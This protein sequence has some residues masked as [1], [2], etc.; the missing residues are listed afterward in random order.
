MNR[1]PFILSQLNINIPFQKNKIK[2]E[3]FVHVQLNEHIIFVRVDTGSDAFY[4]QNPPLPVPPYAY[5]AGCD[6]F[7]THL[8]TCR[9][10]LSEAL[11]LYTV[12]GYKLAGLDE[13]TIILKRTVDGELPNVT[14]T[15]YNKKELEQG[16]GVVGRPFVD[17]ITAGTGNFPNQVNIKYKIH[18][19]DESETIHDIERIIDIKID[20]NNLRINNIPNDK[21][22]LTFILKTLK[23]SLKDICWKYLILNESDSNLINL[24]FTHPIKIIQP[25]TFLSLQDCIQFPPGFTH[26]S[27]H[28]VPKKDA[29]A[30]NAKRMYIR[31][32]NDD[33]MMYT[34]QLY[35]KTSNSEGGKIQVFISKS[36][37]RN[38]K[39]KERKELSKTRLFDF[40]EFHIS[41]EILQELDNLYYFFL[42]YN[43]EHISIIEKTDK[44]NTLLPTRKPKKLHSNLI[45]G[46]LP[47]GGKNEPYIC[48]S[49]LR[50]IPYSYYGKCE[51]ITSDIRPFSDK[52]PCCTIQNPMYKGFK[53]R[54][55][56]IIKK[57]GITTILKGDIRQDGYVYLKGVKRP[58]YDIDRNYIILKDT[59]EKIHR[60]VF[61][62]ETV[63]P[64][65]ISIYSHELLSSLFFLL[66]PFITINST[67]TKTWLREILQYYTVQELKNKFDNIIIND[68]SLLRTERNYIKQEGS[69]YSIIVLLINNTYILDYYGNCV[70]YSK[71]NNKKKTITYMLYDPMSIIVQKYKHRSKKEKKT[72]LNENPVT[73]YNYNTKGLIVSNTIRLPLK[74][75]SKNSLGNR[76][77]ELLILPFE[78]L[79]KQDEWIL[80]EKNKIEDKWFIIERNVKKPYLLT[81]TYIESFFL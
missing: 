52:G 79:F 13:N 77:K 40:D 36:S 23:T 25:Y 16:K 32:L 5:C 26:M 65:D 20:V 63:Y 81:D 50:P 78:H 1:Y 33:N 19:N 59:N 58:I 73:F 24:I 76:V 28:F 37:D 68:I 75:Y 53:K 69:L 57:G 22:T 9:Y 14:T 67:T 34:I 72:I 45:S 18:P 44:E 4:Y 55:K 51:N 11:L 42:T 47:T 10:Q 80:C 62:R 35:N 61:D 46:Y 48:A 49:S 29:N 43:D 6:Q 8:E 64:I 12:E 7:D 38:I 2:L 15:G 66:H 71:N 30:A 54:N 27:T 21:T 70:K 31:L 41:D 17:K 60:S 39:R 3:D 56:V 74:V